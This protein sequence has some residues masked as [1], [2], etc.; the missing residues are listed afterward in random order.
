MTLVFGWTFSNHFST[1]GSFFLP[2]RTVQWVEFHLPKTPRACGLEMPHFIHV[3][4][5]VVKGHTCSTSFRAV[6]HIKSRSTMTVDFLHFY[7]LKVSLFCFWTWLYIFHNSSHI[8]SGMSV[9]LMW[10]KGGFLYFLSL[11]SW[12]KTLNLC[13]FKI[14]FF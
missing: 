10:G 13:C 5:P 2:P 9:C 6:W 7:Q 8:L 12:L 11:V 1:N 4:I 3:N 14:F